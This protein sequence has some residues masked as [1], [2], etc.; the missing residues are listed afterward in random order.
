M[1]RRQLAVL[2]IAGGTLLALLISLCIFHAL[3]LFPPAQI[4]NTQLPTL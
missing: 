4:T 3:G 1:T 2:I